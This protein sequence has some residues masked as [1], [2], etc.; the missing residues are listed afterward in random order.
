MKSTEELREL[1][2]RCWKEGFNTELMPV[3]RTEFAF[4]E[5]K[6]QQYVSPETARAWNAVLAVHEAQKNHFDQ[7][8]TLL[9]AIVEEYMAYTGHEGASIDPN[10]KQFQ[11]MNQAEQLLNELGRMK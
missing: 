4:T 7:L 3:D 10:E 9:S 11:L 8:H 5:H 6:D 1:F 2:E